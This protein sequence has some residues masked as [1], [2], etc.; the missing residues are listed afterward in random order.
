LLAAVL[1]NRADFAQM[2]ADEAWLVP[3]VS[4]ATERV[5]SLRRHGRP[6]I[7]GIDDFAGTISKSRVV[8]LSDVHGDAGVTEGIRRAVRWLATRP[9]SAGRI[10]YFGLEFL[11][12]SW[13]GAETRAIAARVE[14]EFGLGPT[15]S[16]LTA[17]LVE[18]ARLQN[19]RVLALNDA[20]FALRQCLDDQGLPTRHYWHC[21]TQLIEQRD[22]WAGRRL[23]GAEGRGVVIYGRSHVLSGNLPK[24]VRGSCSVITGDP[25]LWEVVAAKIDCS[26]LS[27]DTMVVVELAPRL[28]LVHFP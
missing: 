25:E 9:G 1:A 10:D 8:F 4:A 28:F 26:A 15:G 18:Q 24:L 16:G 22:L 17:W 14:S 6:A 12:D 11:Y 3:Y 21:V 13:I 7:V 5:E 19:A 20:A 2:L 27:A 23:S